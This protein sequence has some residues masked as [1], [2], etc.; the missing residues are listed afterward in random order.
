MFSWLNQENVAFS[1]RVHTVTVSERLVTYREYLPALI[2]QCLGCAQKVQ[3]LY[4][5]NPPDMLQ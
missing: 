1:Q 2:L 5:E 3:V 4:C